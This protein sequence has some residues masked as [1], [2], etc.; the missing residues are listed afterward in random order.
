V[1][2]LDL[3]EVVEQPHARTPGKHRLWMKLN[4]H[5]RVFVV[6]H[7]HDCAVF[8]P[9]S[10]SETIRQGLRVDDQAM[11]SRHLDVR[12]KAVKQTLLRVTNFAGSTMSDLVAYDPPTV[13][14]GNGLVTQAH[15]K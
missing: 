5:R 11:I 12:G 13:G 6:R 15:A 3:H 8:A 9:G 1:D 14:E 10:D 2:G 7:G 4:A